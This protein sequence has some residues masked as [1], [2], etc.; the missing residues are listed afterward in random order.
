MRGDWGGGNGGA[1]RR[2]WGR[3]LSNAENI[4][5][6][7]LKSHE[8]LYPH[9]CRHIG[10]DEQACAYEDLIVDGEPFVVPEG[11]LVNIS[12]EQAAA[13]NGTCATHAVATMGLAQFDVSANK[14]T[15]ML[16]TTFGDLVNLQGID[17]SR[18]AD[19]GAEGYQ[20]PGSAITDTDNDGLISVEEIKAQTT[21]KL[22]AQHYVY[23]SMIPTEMGTLKKLQV[24]K[25]D[26][27]RFMRHM[28]TE[29]GNMR[30][31]RYWDV[32]GTFTAG[33]P[34]TNAVSG[35]I[36]TQF[37]RLKQLLTF[38]M[39]NNTLSGTIPV[40]IANMSSLQQFVVPEN[41]LSGS[42]PPIFGGPLSETLEWWDTF[43]N[44]L[45]G[46]IPSSIGE[47]KNMEYLYIQNEHTDPLRNYFCQERIAASANGQKYNWQMIANDYVSM[48]MPGT[49]VNPLDVSGA[50]DQ[51]S[52]D[53]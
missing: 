11:G 6:W 39:E 10:S 35:S 45:T 42:I 51:L 28:P 49:C 12:A 9:L 31:M 53:V 15:G 43:N 25:M 2:G 14:L 3:L 18:N 48:S 1:S 38:N 50:F 47:L 41:K 32:K 19:L 29:I 30:S 13:F 44:K 46:D 21:D 24:L 40:D 4:A 52:G 8:E 5:G 37:G 20:P 23:H 36:P 17:V 7:S 27:S 33:D 22:H 16:P 26:N 34:E